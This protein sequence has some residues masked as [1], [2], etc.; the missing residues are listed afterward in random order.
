MGGVISNVPFVAAPDEPLP[1]ERV[2]PAI[3]EPFARPNI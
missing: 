1:D 3:A 2:D